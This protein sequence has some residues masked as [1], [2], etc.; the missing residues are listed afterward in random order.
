MNTFYMRK[1]KSLQFLTAQFE[2]L[3]PSHQLGKFHLNVALR[4]YHFFH[5]SVRS[6]VIYWDSSVSQN[7]IN[8][9]HSFCPK[10]TMSVKNERQYFTFMNDNICIDIDP[11]GSCNN[12]SYLCRFFNYL[13]ICSYNASWFETAR[14]E[15]ITIGEQKCISK[16]HLHKNKKTVFEVFY[17]FMRS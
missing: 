15:F 6:T 12:K 9:Y 14:V 3:E 10:L 7:Q 1:C 2:F 4:C 11:T 16:E 5:C 13:I 8:K 17:A